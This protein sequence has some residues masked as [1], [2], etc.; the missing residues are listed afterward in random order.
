MQ[1]LF[2]IQLICNNMFKTFNGE[3]Q[4]WSTYNIIGTQNDN[5]SLK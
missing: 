4:V 1:I 2:C 3:N 5:R